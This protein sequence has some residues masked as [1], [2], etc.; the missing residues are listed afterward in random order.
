MGRVLVI[1]SGFAGLWAALAAAR[2]VD[3]I[4]PEAD[5]VEITVVT[6]RP[7]HDIRVRNYETDLTDCRIPLETLLDPVGV[8][9][10]VAD[11]TAIDAEAR[12]VTA[13]QDGRTLVIGYDRLVLAAGSQ[14][15]RPDVPG[16]REFGFDVDT[17]D[18]AR[19]LAAH[20][21]TLAANPQTSGAGTVVVVGAGLTGIETACE[22]PTRL[23]ARFGDT[24]TPRVL[25]VDHNPEVGSDMGASARPV[26]ET[27]LSDNGV[28]T[29]TGVSVAAVDLGA[30]TMSPGNMVPT[31]TVVWCAGMRANP[32]TAQLPVTLDRFGRLPVDDYLRV[33]GVPG[34]FAAGD[35]AA[36]RVDDNHL[37]VMSCQHGR[38]MGRYAGYNVVGDLLGRPLR[39]L[40]I[41]WYVTVLDLGPSGAV[42]TEGWDRHVVATGAV[43][44]ATKKTINTERIYPPLNGDRREILAAA[45]PDLQARPARGQ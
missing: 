25:L 12:N 41:P 17:F 24:L 2:R 3:E 33:E 39:A 14:V 15:A 26:I 21:D 31:A 10:V 9:H 23:A 27:A 22:M 8:G 16:L 42:Y 36:A 19:R 7:F 13:R 30:V 20:L 18:G 4:G 40:R 38:P 1:G 11:V 45:A 44:K 5:T 29:M 34:V 43:A 32:L 37:S 6:N 28:Q 35:V